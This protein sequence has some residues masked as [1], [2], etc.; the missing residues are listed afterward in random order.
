VPVTVEMAN[1]QLVKRVAGGLGASIAGQA[2]S[3]GQTYLLVPFFLYAWGADGYGHW[4]TL[5]AIISYLTLLDFGGQNYVQN[6]LAMSHARGDEQ[7][8]SGVLSRGFSA[9]L[10]IGVCAFLVYCSVLVLGSRAAVPI[11]GRSLEH[12]EVMTLFFSG[13]NLLLLSIPFGVYATTYRATG[14]FARAAMLGNATRVLGIVVSMGALYL[15][16]G[17]S[18][19]AAC[20]L[21]LAVLTTGVLFLDSRR[22]IPACR[23]VK[24]GWRQF[25]EGT[26]YWKGASSFALLAVALAINQQGLVLVLAKYLGPS[27][28][29]IYVTHRAMAN[30]SGYVGIAAQGP[31]L[32]EFTRLWSQGQLEACQ[33]LLVMS[34]RGV[35]VVTGLTGIC[36]WLLLPVVYPL[37]TGKNFA[38]DTVLF[39]V[40]LAQGVLAAAWSTPSWVLLATNFHSR[41]ALAS[42]ANAVLSIALAFWLVPH[43]G[44]LGA[45][46][47]SLAGDL[48]FG[49]CVL[50]PLAA[51]FLKLK[52][53]A[54]YRQIFGS[55]AALSPVVLCAIVLGRWGNW[56]AAAGLAALMLL[57]L[58]PYAVFVFGKDRTLRVAR[59]LGF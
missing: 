14:L 33:S 17:L 42:L 45:A 22:R 30:L 27:T 24:I 19:Y 47:S 35:V 15:R 46:A 40:I 36:L 57:L 58:Y 44:A 16:V 51:S 25:V 8:F 39:A 5:T 6:L 20:L 50:P 56:R 38:A 49:F 3:F 29:A 10:F 13:A 26:A 32:P 28:V 59:Q 18:H 31:L 48:V 34:L 1:T 55:I 43:G 23:A 54:I 11:I 4:L 9:S 53:T 2:I 37:W 7:G 41:V 12:L 52:I 21:A